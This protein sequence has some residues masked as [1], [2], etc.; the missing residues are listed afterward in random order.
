MT[1]PVQKH[2]TSGQVLRFGLPSRLGHWFHAISFLVL[3]VTGLGL[4]F[5]GI[6]GVSTLRTFGEVHRLAAWPFT[7][8][9]VI[10]L[11]IGARKALGQWLASIIKFDADDRRFLSLF[12]R[13]F[14]GLKV[15][16]PAQ[17][18]FNAGEKINSAIQIL[19]WVAM[20][21]TGWMLVYKHQFSPEVIRWTLTIHSFC[22]L[23]LGSVALGHIYL[24]VGH[25]HSRVAMKGMVNGMVPKKWA[26]GHHKKWA[27]GL[28]D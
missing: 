17:G 7:F 8:A 5:K 11:V 23:L 27:D 24:A 4:V 18:K 9:A 12:W 26:R 28:G 25:P 16:L 20:V 6:V 2:E 1:K 22:A 21:A 14:F 15:N 19:G 13:E 10:I 3:F